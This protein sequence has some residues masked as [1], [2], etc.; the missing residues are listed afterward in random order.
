MSGWVKIHRSLQE[1]EWYGHENC[2]IVFIDILLQANYE[3][4]QYRGIFIPKGSLTTSPEKIG[5]RTG[6]SRGQVRTVLDKLVSTN[7]ITTKATNQFTMITVTNWEKFQAKEDQSNQPDSQP[8]NKRITTSKKLRNQEAKND[9][10]ECQI[11]DY[12]N[13]AN[14]RS[15]KQ[16]D[17]N[18]KEIRARLK[19][20]HS[21]DDLK[22][23]ID[24]A[25]KVW[26]KDPFW[27]DKNRLSTLFNSKFDGYLQTAKDALKPKIDPLMALAQKHL[28]AD[29]LANTEVS[30]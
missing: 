1:W 14:G 20:G 22:Q 18:Y 23:L 13:Q 9:A 30:K 27:C 24:H 7:E 2:L 10:L 12:Y 17:S 4:G 26:S 11:V 6:L 21:I 19:E 8:A 29:A 16:L 25:A 15:L 3:D 28:D 5:L